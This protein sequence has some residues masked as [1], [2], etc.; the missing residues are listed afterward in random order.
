MRICIKFVRHKCFRVSKLIKAL[1][2]EFVSLFPTLLGQLA[3]VRSCIFD[4][5]DHE[6]CFNLPICLVDSCIWVAAVD[7]KRGENQE[8][9]GQKHEHGGLLFKF[10]F[11]F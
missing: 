8:C 7:S 6:V 9:E 3:L 4:H 2:A 5:L 1:L 11:K 10:K